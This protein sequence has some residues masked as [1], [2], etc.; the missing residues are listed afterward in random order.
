M[1][2]RYVSTR[3]PED[4]VQHFRVTEWRPE[5]ALEP[6]WNVAP[7][8]RVWAVLERAPR[9][10]RE[11]ASARRELR[12]L[13]WGLVPSWAKDAR[14]G[15]RLINARAETVHEKPAFRRAFVKRRCLPPGP[16]APPSTFDL[17]QCAVLQGGG[18]AHLKT[19]LARTVGIGLHY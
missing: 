15:A 11:A 13:R 17:A 3:S 16:T 19:V 18:E 14:I 10:N 2:G 7:T 6:S 1:C 5:E 4:L 12:P 9:E 8:N